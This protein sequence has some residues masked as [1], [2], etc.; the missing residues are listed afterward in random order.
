MKARYLKDISY[1]EDLYDWYT[2]KDCRGWIQIV[3]KKD[4][5]KETEK[6]NKKEQRQ[7]DVLIIDLP[8]YFKKGEHYLKKE[9]TI[10]KW[11]ENDCRKDEFIK[12]HPASEEYCPKCNRQMKLI[13]EDL[14]FNIDGSDMKMLFIYRCDLC[15]EKKGLYSNGESYV[16][17]G[18]FCPKCR[19]KWKQKYIKSKEK[20]ITKSRCAYC[21]YKKEDVLDFTENIV[22]DNPDADFEKDRKE[23]CLSKK[24]GER[25]RNWLTFDYPQL[26][27]L[28][29]G[30]EERQ[31]NKNLYDAVAKLK[32]LTISELSDLLTKELGRLGYKGFTI[33]DTEVG[34]DLIIA[35]TIQDTKADRQENY[36]ESDLK[37]ALKKILNNTNWRLMSDGINYKLGLLTGRLRGYEHEEDLLKLV[38]KQNEKETQQ[39]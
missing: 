4:L 32:K 13:I 21:G 11:I 12:N 7:L 25:Y 3:T 24:E 38:K 10:Q 8:L 39:K 37:K 26:K 9:E 28:V 35:F 19:K 17:E 20:I 27:E 33:T 36:S 18:D 2:V 22:K 31:K 23:F 6:L 5:P 1:Y 15:K 14:R 30:Y 16:F 34:R 29:D